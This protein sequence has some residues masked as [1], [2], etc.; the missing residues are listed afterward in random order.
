MERVMS[1]EKR[2]RRAEEI[3]EKR[4]QGETRPITKVS[5]N[6]TQKKEVVSPY[7]SIKNKNKPFK[8]IIISV[9]VVVILAILGYFLASEVSGNDFQDTNITYKIRR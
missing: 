8:I 6:N 9:I 7:T 2:I 5:V 1:V 4:R 3:Y